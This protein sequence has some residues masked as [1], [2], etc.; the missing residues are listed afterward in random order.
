MEGESGAPDI[1]LSE[2]SGYDQDMQDRLQ[3]A[4][5]RQPDLSAIAIQLKQVWVVT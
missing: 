3:A 4:G 5:F 2:E 1:S